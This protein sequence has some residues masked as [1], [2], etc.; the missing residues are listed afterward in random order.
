[1]ARAARS[2]GVGPMAAVAG[3]MAELAV[4]AALKAGAAEAI[5]DNGGDIFM[6][7]TSPVVIGLHT[8]TVK[9][10]DRLAFSLRPEDTPIS[11]CSSSGRSDRVPPSWV[12]TSASGGCSG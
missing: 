12:M 4:E 9:L 5:V 8:G 10:A 2:V 3:A 11:I 1:M 6:R 7:A